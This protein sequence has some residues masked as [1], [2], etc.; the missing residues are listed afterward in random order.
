MQK[1]LNDGAPLLALAQAKGYFESEGIKVEIIQAPDLASIIDAVK[2]G[3]AEGGVLA[4]QDLILAKVRD[5]NVDLVYT[6]CPVFTTS[7]YVKTDAGGLCVTKDSP[8]QSMAD[9]KKGMKVAMTFAPTY[10]DVF[11]HKPS[12]LNPKTDVQVISYSPENAHKAILSGE[13]DYGH[14]LGGAAQAEVNK[15]N[16]RKIAIYSDIDATFGQVGTSREILA[17]SKKF[18]AANPDA[19]ASIARG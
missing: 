19:A 3:Q 13:V 16:L 4:P 10:R 9:I 7:A 8:I 6:C 2:R 1:N 5:S 12:G 14:C 18:A 11:M 15:G 17:V